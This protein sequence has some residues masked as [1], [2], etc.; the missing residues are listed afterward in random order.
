M[1]SMKYK[2]NHQFDSK[3]QIGSS[4]HQNIECQINENG[5][6]SVNFLKSETKDQNAIILEDEAVNVDYDEDDM[7][8]VVI[9]A[10]RQIESHHSINENGTLNRQL[11]CDDHKRES[12]DE[13]D[14]ASSS[15]SGF[16]TVDD[17]IESGTV[18]QKGN[19]D[20][21]IHQT[22]HQI[23]LNQCQP[24]QNDQ[25]SNMIQ[26]QQS[27]DSTNS[28][29]QQGQ[30][31]D[32]GGS[33][34]NSNKQQQYPILQPPRQIKYESNR[35]DDAI[36]ILNDNTSIISSSSTNSSSFSNFCQKF[37][38]MLTSFY[39]S[40]FCCYSTTSNTNQTPFIWS[41]LSIFCCCCPL[42]GAVSLYLTHRSKKFK[43]KQKYDLAEKYSNYAEKLNI[44]SL[45]IGVIFYAIAFFFITL[46]IFMYWRP[47]NS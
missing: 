46:V 1:K 35:R 44:A 40:C 41:W 7:N 30:S 31:D 42:L 38:D 12:Q 6:K 8:E 3:T 16:G 15:E 9:I 17:E 43:M 37:S 34:N 27:V 4:N 11:N 21:E 33:F 2:I 23:K 13:H 47:H 32:A 14:S 22:D 18:H 36:N 10:N 29:Q 20:V 24:L 26:Q 5:L 39:Y 19:H 45:I 28:S 25:R